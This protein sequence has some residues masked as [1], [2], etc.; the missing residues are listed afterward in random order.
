M[1]DLAPAPSAG[2]G[3]GLGFAVRISEGQNPLPGTVGTHYW[4][5][6]F[7]TTFWIDPVE[8]LVGIMMIQVPLRKDGHLQACDALSHISGAP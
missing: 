3:F 1:A 7:G 8:R 6:A 4:T 2:Q 5:G